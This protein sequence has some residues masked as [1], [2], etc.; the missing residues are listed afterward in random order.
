VTSLGLSSSSDVIIFDQNWH[1]LCPTSAG[2]KDLSNDAYFTMIGLLE[3]ETCTKML[4]KMSKKLSQ[5]SC[6]YTKLLHSKNWPPR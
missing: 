6:H 5:I 2:G 3:P 4:K 1:R